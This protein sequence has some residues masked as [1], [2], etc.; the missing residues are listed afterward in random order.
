MTRITG[1]LAQTQI[2]IQR[3]GGGAGNLGADQGHGAEVWGTQVS[4]HSGTA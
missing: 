4:P 2:L 3:F 1:A